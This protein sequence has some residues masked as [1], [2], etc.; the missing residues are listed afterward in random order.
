MKKRM[1]ESTDGKLDLSDLKH[2]MRTLL[3]QRLECGGGSELNLR[4]LKHCVRRL[5]I[6]T[7]GSRP[8]WESWIIHNIL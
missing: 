5:L 8:D 7:V 4:D 2:W 6:H 1:L 3:I